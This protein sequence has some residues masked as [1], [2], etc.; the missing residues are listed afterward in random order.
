VRNF[1]KVCSTA[2]TT[3]LKNPLE[4]NAPLKNEFMLVQLMPTLLL[5]RPKRMLF[6]LRGKK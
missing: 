3:L 4:K 5:P 2:T 1:I 6:Y